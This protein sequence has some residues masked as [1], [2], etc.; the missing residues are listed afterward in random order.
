MDIVQAYKAVINDL[1]TQQGYE[2]EA[3]DT[4]IAVLTG[5]LVELV[6]VW[7]HPDTTTLF[8]TPDITPLFGNYKE[9]N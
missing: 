9:E 5:R 1:S 6:F 8:D 4:A 3:K 2:Q 7:G